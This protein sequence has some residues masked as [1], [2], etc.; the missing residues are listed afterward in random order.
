M[1]GLT[2]SRTCLDR[3]HPVVLHRKP[4]RYPIINTGGCVEALD[5]ATIERIA[6]CL[7]AVARRAGPKM[8]GYRSRGTRRGNRLT[9]SMDALRPRSARLVVKEAA[10][11]GSEMFASADPYPH[12]AVEVGV[13]VLL[14]GDVPAGRYT[15]SIGRPWSVLSFG[16]IRSSAA[17]NGA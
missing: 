9:G 10:P 3:S 1:P 14:L 16:C 12:D 6:G 7:T 15:L 17:R 8:E 13:F 4:R 2:R 5:N 11:Q